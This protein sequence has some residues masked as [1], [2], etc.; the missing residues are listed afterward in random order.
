MNVTHDS[1]IVNVIRYKP[2]DVLAIYPRNDSQL[3]DQCLT[4][5]KMDPDQIIE[6]IQKLDP[7][8]P[9]F[10]WVQFPITNREFVE[11]HLYIAGNPKRYFFELLSHFNDDEDEKERL[12]FFGS[13]EGGVCVTVS[14]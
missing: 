8:A 4:M 14:M 5:F 9:G 7:D 12:L 2:G 13:P 1:H 10:D 6:G 11:K 3:V